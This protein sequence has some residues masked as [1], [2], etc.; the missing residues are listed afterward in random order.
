MMTLEVPR[1]ELLASYAAALRTGWLPNTGRDVSAE[2]L[3]RVAQDAGA[4]VASMMWTPGSTITL[5]DG[6]VVERLPGETR[7]MW[8]GAFCGSINF[9][10]LAG[11][12]DLPPHVS[13]HVGYAVVPWKRRRGYA[14]QALRGMLPLA[15]AVG[16][17]RVMVTCDDDNLASRRVIEACGGVSLGGPLVSEDTARPK[18]R[19]WIATGL[20]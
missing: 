13:G 16:L 14:S 20:D 3:A 15:A 7:W 9:R 11:T 10:H 19:Y 2:Q 4:F 5:E 12:E 18:L 1:L 17:S 6:R 8:D